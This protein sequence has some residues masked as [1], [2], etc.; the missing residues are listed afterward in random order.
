MLLV[1]NEWWWFSW[2]DSNWRTCYENENH[3]QN[4]RTIN[5]YQ[6]AI[7][8]GIQV[9]DIVTGSGRF[10]SIRWIENGISKEV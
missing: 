9:E 1:E 6:D 3:A 10:G 2:K 7:D 4:R 5:S 8:A